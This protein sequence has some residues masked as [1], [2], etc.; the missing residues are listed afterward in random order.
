MLSYVEGIIPI[1][2]VLP[3]PGF[4]LGLANLAVLLAFFT[5]GFYQA[6]AVSICRISLSA[7]LFGSVTS[8][9]YSITGGLL[10]L[11]VLFMYKQILH[12][13][14]GLLGLCVL[15]AAMHNVGQCI[16]CA[17]FFGTSVITFY[18]PYLLIFS[19]ITGAVT[20]LISSNFPKLRRL[21]NEAI[22]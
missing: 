15:C 17:A 8:F 9:L 16:V 4:K 19:L 6:S 7:I 5:L 13:K 14:I 20:G 22:K 12:K 21:I 11:A 10:T 1:N 3:F 18:L 2:A